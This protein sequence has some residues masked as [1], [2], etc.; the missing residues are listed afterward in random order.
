MNQSSSRKKVLTLVHGTF[1][2]NAAWTQEHSE[3]YRALQQ[4][5]GGQTVHRRIV[6]RGFLGSCANNGHDYRIAGGATLAEALRASFREFP[7]AEHWVIAHSHGGNVAFYALRDQEVARRLDGIV[8][9][10]TPFIHCKRRTYSE[11]VIKLWPF[12]LLVVSTVLLV[13]LFSALSTYVLGL[14]GNTTTIFVVVGSL[15]CLI[16]VI[17]LYFRRKHLPAKLSARQNATSEK[18]ILPVPT[19]QRVLCLSILGDEARGLLKGMY[20]IA[21][22]PHWLWNELIYVPFMLVIFVSALIFGDTFLSSM[23]GKTRLARLRGA[24]DAAL[25]WGMLIGYAHLFVMALLPKLTRALG[26]G[27]GQESLVD[28]LLV[29]IRSED[30]PGG[31][32]GLIHKQFPIV[33][34]SSLMHSRLYQNPEVISDIARFIAGHPIS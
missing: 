24:F 4:Q 19:R 3:F 5:L 29:D 26:I 23:S 9:M 28:N 20:M 18:L 34:G 32:S 12:V 15:L 27:F 31:V 13:P 33:P 25:G 8:S 7:D 2:P 6:W 17:T 21:A 1:A 11:S 22:W 14:S 16:P 10:A 30:I